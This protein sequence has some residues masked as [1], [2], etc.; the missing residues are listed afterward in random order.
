MHRPNQIWQAFVSRL[1][2]VDWTQLTVCF[3]VM[4]RMAPC[5]SV[6]ALLA[7]IVLF[8]LPP[9]PFT[10]FDFQK[11]CLAFGSLVSHLLPDQAR[12]AL[13]SPTPFSLTLSAA[14]SWLLST[15]AESGSWL[16]ST[17]TT[18]KVTAYFAAVPIR[19]LD[20]I[21]CLTCAVVLGFALLLF[22][23]VNAFRKSVN[24]S[25]RQASSKSTA[26]ASGWQLIS[27]IT[28]LRA[29][30]VRISRLRMPS[31]VNN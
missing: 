30:K 23:T 11:E 13:K 2:T 16:T 21:G 20:T 4:G 18:T 3:Q 7:A 6:G 14:S 10:K 12:F 31:L 24:S 17:V 15:S 1:C 5:V 9:T 8:S 19:G 29:P 22:R 26:S 25:T 27:N 28:G